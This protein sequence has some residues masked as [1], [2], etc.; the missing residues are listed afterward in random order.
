MV[1]IILDTDMDTDCDD[2]AAV[3]LLHVLADRGEV[4]IL[5][6]LVS[7]VFPGSVGTLRAIHAYYGRPDVPV[8]V[9]KGRAASVHRG[10]RYAAEVAEEFGFAGCEAQTPDAVDVLRRA[11]ASEADGSVVIVTIGYLT[12]LSNLLRS[13]P[14]EHSD[15]PGREL[16]ERKVRTYVCMGSVYPA[17]PDPRE[18]GNFKPDPASVLHVVAEWPTPITFT[19]GGDFCRRLPTGRGLFTDAPATSPVRRV[20]ELFHRGVPKH[21]HSAD[22][23]AVMVAVRGPGQP[24]RAVTR[25]HNH[26]FEN[27]THEWRDEPDDPR[28]QYV[29]NLVEGV[30][31]EEVA[32]EIETLMLQPPSAGL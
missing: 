25:G 9:V 15:L 11:L 32:D 28:Q 21:H 31:F 17:D 6:T 12:N 3:G 16:V 18:W 2:A 13:E 8:G 29:A 30:T 23:I 22:Q 4:R 14:D 10:S 20:Y 24:W 26:I 5:A 1:P 7:S 27:G 19:G